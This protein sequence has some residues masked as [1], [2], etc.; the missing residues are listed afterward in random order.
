MGLVQDLVLG[1][2]SVH[3]AEVAEVVHAFECL[4]HEVGFGVL[5]EAGPHG[6]LQGV[7]LLH[8]AL[9]LASLQ[10][11]AHQISVFREIQ[12][13]QTACCI[14]GSLTAVGPVRLLRR[15]CLVVLDAAFEVVLPLG[16][17]NL[18]T[19]ARL[20]L[21]NRLDLDLTLFFR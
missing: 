1:V 13:V 5:L 18:S 4:G 7:A 12:R 11:G 2:T 17:P 16:A 9:E 6:L 10:S 14:E 15:F 21:E 20:E 19:F 8:D 3:L